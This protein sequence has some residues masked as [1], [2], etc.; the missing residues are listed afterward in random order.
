[1]PKTECIKE[2]AKCIPAVLRDKLADGFFRYWHLPLPV[3]PAA[4]KY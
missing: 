2:I 3:V 1:M 4:R